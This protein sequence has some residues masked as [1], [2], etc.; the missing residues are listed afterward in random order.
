MAE[1]AFNVDLAQVQLDQFLSD[2]EPEAES[3][4]AGA[5]R[6]AQLLETAKDRSLILGV[7]A[8]TVVAHAELT[9]VPSGS[10]RQLSRTRPGCRRT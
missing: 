1:L 7:D 6:F 4:G 9:P 5:K 10:G 3:L 8:V 2:V